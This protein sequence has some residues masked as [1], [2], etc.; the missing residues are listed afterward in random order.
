MIDKHRSV[1]LDLHGPN[2][3]RNRGSLPLQLGVAQRLAGPGSCAFTYSETKYIHRFIV[4]YWLH[5]MDKFVVDYMLPILR[6]HSFTSQQDINAYSVAVYWVGTTTFHKTYIFYFFIILFW[7]MAHSM[8]HDG[9]RYWECQSCPLQWSG[10][11]HSWSMLPA[12]SDREHYLWNNCHLPPNLVTCEQKL[13]CEG[14]KRAIW[15]RNSWEHWL[16]RY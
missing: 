11:T 1:F 9:A 16:T 15:R 13:P 5:D 2:S 6:N 12:P 14:R 7:S 3:S 4:M 8:V 10:L